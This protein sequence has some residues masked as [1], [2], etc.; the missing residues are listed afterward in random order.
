LTLQGMDALRRQAE[1][2]FEEF[3]KDVHEF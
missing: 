2:L 1:V 3:L